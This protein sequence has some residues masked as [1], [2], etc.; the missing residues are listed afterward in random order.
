MTFAQALTEAAKAV[1]KTLVVASIPASDTE[2]GGEGGRAALERIKNV[3]A[4]IQSPWT[5]ASTEEGFEIVRRRLFQA[6]TDN[7][8]FR[9][10]DAIARKFREMYGEHRQ[11][12]PAQCKEAEYERRIQKAYPIHPELF[13]RLFGDWST[14][15]KFQMTRGVLRLM[16]AVIHTLWIRGDANLL[17]MPAHVPVDE[18]AVQF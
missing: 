6:I 3:F 13:D 1:P 10:R 2:I 7:E 11:E 5:P 9:A 4:R 14:L 8:L 12:F 15:E 17:I 18:P 16:A